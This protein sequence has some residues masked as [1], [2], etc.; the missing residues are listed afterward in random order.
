MFDWLPNMH[1][2]QKLRERCAY[3]E[4]KSEF[5]EKFGV[6]FKQHRK[7]WEFALFLI[8]FQPNVPL[9]EIENI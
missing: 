9:M 1:L 4:L 3:S 5:G 7:V 6:K 8:P 2:L